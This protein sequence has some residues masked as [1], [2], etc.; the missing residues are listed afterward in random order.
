MNC[1]EKRPWKP[2]GPF[3]VLMVILLVCTPVPADA[4]EDMAELWDDDFSFDVQEFEKKDLEW[5]GFIELKGI[6]AD[7]DTGSPCTL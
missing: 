6:H 3:W 2:Y 7:V 4:N 5:G 1:A